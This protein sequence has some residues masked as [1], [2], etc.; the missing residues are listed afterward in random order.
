[1]I[2]F[3]QSGCLNMPDATF[4]WVMTAGAVL[5]ALAC[6]LWSN[7]EGQRRRT[8]MRRWHLAKRAMDATM[9]QADILFQSDPDLTLIWDEGAG[10]EISGL[11][12]ARTARGPLQ[13][14]DHVLGRGKALE[15]PMH[16]NV[17]EAHGSDEVAVF[18]QRFEIFLTHLT[19]TSRARFAEA[20]DRLR[21]DGEGFCLALDLQHGQVI[22]ANGRPAGAQS[23]VKLRDVSP[24]SSEIDRLTT[25]LQDAE[26]EGALAVLGEPSLCQSR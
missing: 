12:N 7:Y 15:L 19:E 26:Q 8:I 5:F 20:V 16:P 6:A 23:V 22:E 14:P 2:R 11:A 21:I 1:V 3:S 18:E 24:E 25:I 10:T 13:S 17:G 4:Q 9:S